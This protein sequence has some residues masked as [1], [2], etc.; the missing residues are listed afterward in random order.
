LKALSKRGKRRNQKLLSF[1]GDQADNCRHGIVMQ[2]PLKYLVQWLTDRWPYAVASVVIGSFLLA[3]ALPLFKMWFDL[4]A[5]KQDFDKDALEIQPHTTEPQFVELE[6]L[7]TI[8][9]YDPN[10]LVS[11]KTGQHQQQQGAGENSDALPIVVGAVIVFFGLIIL[12]AW[13][14]NG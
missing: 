3:K 1:S 5:Q 13:I 11:E 8:P 7:E 12:A 14:F 6:G 2:I 4:R 9:H 10:K